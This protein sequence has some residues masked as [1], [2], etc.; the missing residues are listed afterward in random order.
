MKE[1]FDIKNVI[2]AINN[3]SRKNHCSICLDVLDT[4]LSTGSCGHCF[5][6]K[7]IK[8]LVSDKCPVCRTKTEYIKIHL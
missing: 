4:D 2:Q 7:C 1:K 6:T 3:N 5:H 8:M